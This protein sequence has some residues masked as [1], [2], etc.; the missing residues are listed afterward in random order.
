MLPDVPSIGEFVPGYETSAVFGLGAPK[1]TP[2][3]IVDKLNATINEVLGE[4][5]IRARLAD[6]GATVLTLSPA[7]YRELL[8]EETAKWAK[9]IEAANIKLE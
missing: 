7:K 6:L 1:A 5:K 4:E 2:V 3:D 8:V 9:V